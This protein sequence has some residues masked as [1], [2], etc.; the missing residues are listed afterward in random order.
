MSKI[1]LT[2]KQEKFCNEYIR[3]GN[4]SEAYRL[5]YDARNMADETINREA[6]ELYN[7]PKITTRIKE[8]RKELAERNK[9]TLDEVVQHISKIALFDIAECYD[10]NQRLKPIQEIPKEIRTAIT[11]IK[12]YEDKFNTQGDNI[13]M[14]ETKELKIINKLDA[15]EKLMKHLGGYEKDNSQKNKPALVFFDGRKKQSDDS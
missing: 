15:F 5:A 11:G 3:T 8:L 9:I 14:G 1:D 12:V 6:H 13:V 4:K 2:P 7:N 10:E